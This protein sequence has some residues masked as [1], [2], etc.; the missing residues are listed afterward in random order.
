MVIM[1]VTLICR[2]PLPTGGAPPSCTLA[3]SKLH[4]RAR[5]LQ[6][7]GGLRLEDDDDDT[8]YTAI[9]VR[10]LGIVAHWWTL[11]ESHLL[12]QC[13]SVGWQWSDDEGI[14]NTEKKQK[15]IV[16]SLLFQHE[17][18][19]AQLVS[20]LVAQLESKAR[21]CLTIFQIL[22]SLKKTH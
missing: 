4:D 2:W 8:A 10:Y 22:I 12:R 17:E 16:A 5:P 13:T 21:N 14:L 7:T 9:V 1:I 19:A 3:W 15:Q 11:C 20:Q 18:H 6:P